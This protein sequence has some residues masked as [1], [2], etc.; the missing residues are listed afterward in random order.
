[1]QSLQQY[2]RFDTANMLVF[3]RRVCTLRI[4]TAVLAAGAA[5]SWPYPRAV[6]GALPLPASTCPV[7]AAWQCPP[8]RS[9]AARLH[10]QVCSPSNA[11]RS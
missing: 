11:G 8:P 1:M 4:S 5:W 7:G 9:A 3:L 6:P 2:S 10:S